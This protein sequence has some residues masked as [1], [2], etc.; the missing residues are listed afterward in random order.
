MKITL[1]PLTFDTWT[2]ARK[3]LVEVIHRTVDNSRILGCDADVLADALALHA[4]VDH[5]VGPGVRHFTART[6][7]TYPRTRCI[8][9]ERVDDT[10]VPVSFANLGKDRE[11]VTRYDRLRAL[12][13]A[14]IPQILAFRDKC[15]EG[16]D[17]VTCPVTENSVTVD[18]CEV[19]H[20]SPWTFARLV[21]DWL[22]SEGL[23]L[24][25][26]EIIPP[27]HPH[28]ELADPRLVASWTK[29]HAEHARLR[30]LSRLGHRTI[31][32]ANLGRKS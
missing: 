29:Y 20:T 1:G 7:P 27:P 21:S 18:H 3:Y 19:D 30:I 32:R 5:K 6:H 23:T 11:I 9:V 28:C 4:E 13:K 2:A 17:T 25:D 26:L 8:F 22:E 24:A 10:S 31:T 15:Y 14:V 12:R 16:R